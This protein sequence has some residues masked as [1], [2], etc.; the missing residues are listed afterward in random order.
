LNSV[1][2]IQVVV[3][4]AAT[5]ITGC[6]VPASSSS[7]AAAAAVQLQRRVAVQLL[8]ALN[9]AQ[10]GV[11]VRVG[12]GKSWSASCLC[13]SSTLLV[14]AEWSAG[15]TCHHSSSHST[16]HATIEPVSSLVRGLTHLNHMN[17]LRCEM[18]DDAAND[19]RNYK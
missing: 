13:L 8:H 11:H 1:C 6:R 4:A 16:A 7:A 18:S 3:D 10:R 17:V 19:C 9:A 5:C 2:Q 14:T 12:G 15:P